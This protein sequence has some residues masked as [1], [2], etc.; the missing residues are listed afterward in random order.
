MNKDNRIFVSPNQKNVN[1]DVINIF[2][3]SEKEIGNSSFVKIRPM[4]YEFF[5]SI[6]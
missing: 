5:K 6:K 4:L 1:E 3:I 2:K